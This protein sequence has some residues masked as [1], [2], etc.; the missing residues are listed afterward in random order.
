MYTLAVTNS[1]ADKATGVTVE[2][3][4]P[5]GVEYQWHFPPTYGSFDPSTGTWTIGE[6]L[7]GEM[8]VLEIVVKG[9]A[10][11]TWTKHRCS[12]QQQYRP[13]RPQ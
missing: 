7:N 11:G 3:T 12:I 5:A 2:D 10:A 8:A 1:G 13:E 9:I 6:L 4:L